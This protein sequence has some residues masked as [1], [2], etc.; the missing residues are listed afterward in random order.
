MTP[1]P[2]DILLVGTGNVASHLARALAP[3]IVAVAGRN[4]GH[5]DALA[6]QCA[7]PASISLENISALQPQIILFSV[8][9]SAI[10]QVARQ[11]GRLEHAP[12][13][14]HTSGSIPMQVLEPISPRYGVLYP[15]QTFS[16]GVDVEMCK[17]PFFTEASETSVH[18]I[19]DGVASGISPHVYHAD[20]GERQRL[21]IAGVLS[22]NFTIALL[23]ITRRVLSEAGYSLDVVRPLVEAT[24]A[25]AFGQG[26]Q[27]AMTGPARRG[28]MEVV[29]KHL[30]ALDGLDRDTYLVL[31]R[32][33]L[34]MFNKDCYEQDKL[35]PYPD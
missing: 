28:D 35:R 23:D 14:A 2:R 17:V 30:A 21:H 5:A 16:A 4:T 11:T 25:K 8:A 12:V 13:V 3:R 29:R 9:D 24:V 22:S 32:Q 1:V 20:A 26:P 33:I 31:T 34:A 6:R 7:I 10:A 15:L 27:N 18:S 19:I